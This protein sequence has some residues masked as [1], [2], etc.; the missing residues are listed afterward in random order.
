VTSV[1]ALR[2]DLLAARDA[3]Q[4][5]LDEAVRSGWPA[6]IAVSLAVP[7]EEKAPAGAARLFA[8]AARRVAAMGATPLRR[9]DDALGPFALFALARDP[10]EVKRA[11]VALEAEQPAARLLDADVVGPSGALVD[12][13]AIGLPPRAC[14]CCGE[15]ARD[16][17]RISRHPPA[18]V[19]ARACALLAAFD[20]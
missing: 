8:W 14:L 9:S 20:A 15:P 13:A 10:V 7:G 3:R 17:I 19:V 6:V 11:G 2:R 16:C 12:R 18:E 1:D 5:A 4:A